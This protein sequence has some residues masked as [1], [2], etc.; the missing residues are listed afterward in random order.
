LTGAADPGQGRHAAGLYYAFD[1]GRRLGAFGPAS[2]LTFFPARGP[3]TVPG[4]SATRDGQVTTY[5]ATLR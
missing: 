2:S 3:T 1:Y 4:P 5:T